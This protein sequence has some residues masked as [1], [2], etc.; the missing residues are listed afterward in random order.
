VLSLVQCPFDSG[1]TN[2]RPHPFVF[3]GR[4]WPRRSLSRAAR[5]TQDTWARVVGYVE[6]TDIHSAGLTV[7]ESL[8]Y[9]AG[10]RLTAD[11]D[12]PTRAAYLLEVMLVTELLDI[13]GNLVGEPGVSGLSVEQR[14]RLSIGVELVSNPSVVV[15]AASCCRENQRG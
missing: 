6:Q 2:R 12:T 7:E 11:V 10:L 9:S 8:R 13:R 14:R 3:P 4:S 1:K 15:R 5:R